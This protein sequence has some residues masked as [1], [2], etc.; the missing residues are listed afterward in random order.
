VQLTMGC[1]VTPADRPSGLLNSAVQLLQ[2]LRKSGWAT[3]RALSDRLRRKTVCPNSTP[4]AGVRI[5]ESGCYERDGST[6]DGYSYV[7]VGCKRVGAHRL[8]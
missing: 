3:V 6:I 5:T 2:T 7:R 1:S 8:V 4:Y